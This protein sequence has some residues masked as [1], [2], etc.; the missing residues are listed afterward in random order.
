MHVSGGQVVSSE[1]IWD[2]ST[3]FLNT[4]VLGKGVPD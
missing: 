4:Q 2:L 3:D 1:V